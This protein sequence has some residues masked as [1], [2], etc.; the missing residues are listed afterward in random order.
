MHNN[1]GAMT[2]TRLITLMTELMNKDRLDYIRIIMDSEGGARSLEIAE[3]ILRDRGITERREIT[4][5]NIKIN[6]RL[7]KLV[8]LGIL[9]SSGG[10]YMVSSLGQLLMASWEEVEKNAETI[11]K[12][13]DFFDN[14][15]VTDLPKEFFRQI[16]KINRASLTEIPIQ[17]VQEVIR[18]SKRI[19]RKFY[20]L[21]E[22]LHDIPEEM[23]EKKRKGEIDEIVIIYEFFNYPKLNYSLEEELFFELVSA[24]VDF[25]YI[26]LVDRHPL[27]IRII[28]EKWAT[29]GLPRIRDGMLDRE[30]AF[31]GTDKEFIEW[32]RD[33]M[34]HMWYFEAKLLNVEEVVVK[35]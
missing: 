21:T 28:D 31:I 6:K 33:L 4:R 32:C 22:Y 7:R 18:H 26:D 1:N 23:I 29:F 5:E 10:K 8:G 15:Y 12:F 30:R 19:E 25:R 3:E 27:S 35:K 2:N 17:W 24:G 16:Y 9:N 14:H 34:H 20:N 11:S 13:Y